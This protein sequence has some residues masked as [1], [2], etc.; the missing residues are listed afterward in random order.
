MALSRAVRAAAYR[1][2]VLIPITGFAPGKVTDLS[3]MPKTTYDASAGLTLDIPKLNL[4]M[5]I[6]GVALSHGT[7]DVN[8]LLDRAGWLEQTAFPTFTGNSVVTGHVTLSNGD[9]GPFARLSTLAPGDLVF[10]MPS[11]CFIS[12]KSA[13]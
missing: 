5:P 4:K 13:P 9:P 12:I 8:W 6:V 2:A 10:V 3:G 7:W 11:V 1:G